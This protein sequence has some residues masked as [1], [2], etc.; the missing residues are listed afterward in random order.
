[1]LPTICTGMENQF[2]KED[3]SWTYIPG[4]YPYNYESIM[5]Y[6][7]YALSNDPCESTI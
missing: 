4:N 6:G 5:H 1:M 2:D 7:E 3:G